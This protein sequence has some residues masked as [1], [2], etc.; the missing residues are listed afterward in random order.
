MR[1]CLLFRIIPLKF[2]LIRLICKVH[3]YSVKVQTYRHNLR[4][5]GVEPTTFGFGGQR[6]IQLSYGRGFR[7]L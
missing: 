3:K 2:R 4:P 1:K 6:S 5:A 7:G